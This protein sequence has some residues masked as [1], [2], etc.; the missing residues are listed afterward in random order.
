MAMKMRHQNQKDLDASWSSVRDDD[1][2]PSKSPKVSSPG[3]LQRLSLLT[4]RNED[5]DTSV[6]SFQ[7]TSRKRLSI[8]SKNEDNV[9]D[10]DID[11]NILKSPKLKQ[12][13]MR[14]D[15]KVF[16][17][18]KSMN[19]LRQNMRK[20]L[21]KGK[22]Q[23]DKEVEDPSDDRSTSESSETAQ[24]ELTEEEMMVLLCR[25]FQLMD[26]DEE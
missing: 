21:S 18:V 5:G 19:K 12:D 10:K 15:R 17:P 7:S 1:E 23:G 22:K 14:K 11:V 20:S 6:S 16:S 9:D 25:E 4:R 2:N 8:F 3:P 24:R 13:M 26:D